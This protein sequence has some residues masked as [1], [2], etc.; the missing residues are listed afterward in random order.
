MNAKHDLR[1]QNIQPDNQN[2]V[3]KSKKH[4]HGTAIEKHTIHKPILI[5]EL[6]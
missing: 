2:L 6:N 4:I 3:E 5:L 1:M